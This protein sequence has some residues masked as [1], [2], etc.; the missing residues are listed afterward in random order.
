MS[1]LRYGRGGS[2]AGNGWILTFRV[3]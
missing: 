1:R 2:D 3:G